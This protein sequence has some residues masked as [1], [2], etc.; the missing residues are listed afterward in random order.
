MVKVTKKSSLIL[1]E[2]NK[3]EAMFIPKIGV[4]ISV[5]NTNILLI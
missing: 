5:F 4:K 1:V 3:I 2:F